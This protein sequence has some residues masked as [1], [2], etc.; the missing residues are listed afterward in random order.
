MVNTAVSECHSLLLFAELAGKYVALL[1]E[2]NQAPNI[3]GEFIHTL[4]RIFRWCPGVGLIAAAF[5]SIRAY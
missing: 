3:F 2:A 5:R 1:S 4:H